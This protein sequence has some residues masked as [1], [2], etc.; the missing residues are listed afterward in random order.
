MVYIS[1]HGLHGEIHFLQHNATTVE[2]SA[3]LE[4]TL[5]F[6]DQ[7]WAWNIAQFPVDYTDVNPTTRCSQD[8][9][10]PSVV[11]L[12]EDLGYLVLTDNMTSTWMKELSLTGK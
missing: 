5:Q 11:D 12:D 8:K 6:P 10:G 9:L 1:Q 7:V 2:I 4:T 3:D